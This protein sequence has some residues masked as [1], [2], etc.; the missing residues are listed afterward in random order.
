MET[1]AVCSDESFQLSAN[2]HD[3][4]ADLWSSCICRHNSTIK[5][6]AA[7]DV[8]RP[9]SVIVKEVPLDQMRDQPCFSLPSQSIS[10]ELPTES[11]SSYNQ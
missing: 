3:H 9:A 8:L 7:V 5:A 10:L 2:T 1:K 6:K 4:P 11:A